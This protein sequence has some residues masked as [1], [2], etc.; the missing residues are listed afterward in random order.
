[1][2]SSAPIELSHGIATRAAA[3]AV[4]AQRQ[5]WDLPV[6]IV[7]WSLVAAVLGSYVTY[8][9]GLAYFRY[10]VWC[11]YA[12]LV[13]VTF[14]IAWGLCGT[15]HARFS[16]FVRGP[17]D[18]LRHAVEL[19]QGRVRCYA[20]HN[21]LGAWMV[22]VLLGALLVQ[23]L[24]GLF[25]NDEIAST[26][27]LYGYVGDAL[28]L[29]LT[30]LHRLLF[31]GIAAAILLHVAAVL[32]YRLL[33]KEDLVKAMLTG[34]KPAEAVP[35]AEAI[36]SSRLGLALTLFLVICALLAVVVSHAPAVGIAVE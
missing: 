35:A 8:K 16:A 13:L 25:S 21:P 12:V 24:S 26:G 23:A 9:L 20:G 34:R 17:R 19:A 18:T 28:S 32:A 10:H 30:S 5:V 22:V 36:R 15:R 3:P 4:P 14:R 2:S 33:K 29:R 1:M 6:R 31:G 11:G 27:P 7:H